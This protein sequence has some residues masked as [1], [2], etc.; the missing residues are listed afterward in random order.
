M[1]LPLVLIVGV[2]AHI[3]NWRRWMKFD[4]FGSQNSSI[5]VCISLVEASPSFQAYIYQTIW[6]PACHIVDGFVMICGQTRVA[7][8]ILIL[9]K[10]KTDNAPWQ[11]HIVYY[12]ATYSSI[13][14]DFSSDALDSNL[15]LKLNCLTNQA[16]CNFQ[17]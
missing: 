13:E 14:V 2:I 6:T 5:L 12:L 9:V 3:E 17:S 11:Y 15:V 8:S 10:D 1:G 16:L 4:S 7:K